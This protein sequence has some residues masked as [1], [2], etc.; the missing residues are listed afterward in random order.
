MFCDVFFLML[1]IE[2]NVTST[3]DQYE[4]ACPGETVVFTCT[5]FGSQVKWTSNTLIGVDQR[6]QFSTFVNEIGEGM[7]QTLPNGQRTFA[8]LIYK[9]NMTITTQLRIT[10]PADAGRFNSLLVTCTKEDMP[11]YSNMSNRH[12][13]GTIIRSYIPLLHCCYLQ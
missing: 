8:Q 7:V 1:G 12:V 3:V 11:E 4:G 10:I 13:A 9:D 6:I 2:V 5:A